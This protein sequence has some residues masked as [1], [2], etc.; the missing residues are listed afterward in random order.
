MDKGRLVD[1]NFDRKF[2]LGDTF[3]RAKGPDAPAV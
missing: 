2:L 3:N 1:S